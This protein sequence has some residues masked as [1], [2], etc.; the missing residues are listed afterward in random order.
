MAARRPCGA[1]A[2]T[3]S[4]AAFR[5]P[6]RAEAVASGSTTK[7]P[8]LNKSFSTDPLMPEFSKAVDLLLDYMQWSGQHTLHY[9]LVWY[10]GPLYGSLAEPFEGGY[11]HAAS[12]L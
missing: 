7:D 11:R 6:S 8:V 5:G 4:R 3:G 9:P 2:Y 1:C 12:L 10:R